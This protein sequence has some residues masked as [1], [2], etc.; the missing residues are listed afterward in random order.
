MNTPGSPSAQRL[1][2]EEQLRELEEQVKRGQYVAANEYAT[3]YTR[4]GDKEK[5]FTWLEKATKSTIAS[6]WN[7]RLILF[8]TAYETIHVFRNWL[9]V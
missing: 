7:S 5:A 2:G 6:L 8:T 9:K 1:R 3:A 4:I